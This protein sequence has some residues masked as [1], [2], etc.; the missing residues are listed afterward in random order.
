MKQPRPFS[1]EL[2]NLSARN[3]TKDEV[4]IHEPEHKVV[5]ND[6]LA[7]FFNQRFISQDERVSR[8]ISA[9]SVEEFQSERI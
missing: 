8:S 3:E 1:R 7:D 2:N 6:N 5:V 4:R 9:I